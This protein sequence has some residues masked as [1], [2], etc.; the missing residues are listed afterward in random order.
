MLSTYNTILL[1]QQIYEMSI[2][3]WHQDPD[4]KLQ[5]RAYEMMV[6]FNV[7]FMKKLSKYSIA[8]FIL[9]CGSAIAQTTSNTTL[10]LLRSAL[11]KTV[12]KMFRFISPFL[13]T[14]YDART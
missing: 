5:P 13:D 10:E 1:L 2:F 14:K 11:F 3:F 7:N 4:K 9:C 6:S 8:L 12:H